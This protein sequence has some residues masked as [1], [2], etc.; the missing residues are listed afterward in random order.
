M[1][2]IK[3]IMGSDGSSNKKAAAPE[4]SLPKPKPIPVPSTT[5]NAALEAARIARMQALSR[6]GRAASIL[7]SQQTGLTTGAPVPVFTNTVLGS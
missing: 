3:E 5:D 1:G 2:E 6:R 7:S 4:I